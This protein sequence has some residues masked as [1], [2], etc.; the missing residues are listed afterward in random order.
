[1]YPDGDDYIERD[2]CYYGDIPFFRACCRRSAFAA[3]A[4]GWISRPTA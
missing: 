1:M 3:S 4:L 2:L